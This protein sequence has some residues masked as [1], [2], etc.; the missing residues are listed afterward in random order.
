PGGR[1]H[2]TI[3]LVD[4]STG[5]RA[6]L[7]Q[8]GDVQDVQPHEIDRTYVAS[9][10]IIHLSDASP[11]AVQAARWAKEAGRE[12][13]FDGTHFHP[14]VFALV[15]HVDYLVVSRFFASEFVAHQ[16]GRDV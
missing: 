14:G 12:V 7:S 4:Q 10:R 11:A 3:V 1:S 5:A 9:A 8:R 2:E 15:E 16:E 6:F 13:C